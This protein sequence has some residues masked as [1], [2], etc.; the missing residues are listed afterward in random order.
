[1]VGKPKWK[2][3]E[4]LQLIKNSKPKAIPN[5]WKDCRNQCHHQAL[6]E[7][8]DGYRIPIQL[9]YLAM[10]KTDG[11]E[12]MAVDYCK[13]NQVVILNAPAVTDVI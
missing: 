5:S 1:M 6:K 11:S 8:R 12:S 7:C 10:K 13:L 3:L 4:L 9:A 2:P